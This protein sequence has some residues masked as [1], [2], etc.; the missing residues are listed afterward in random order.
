M[1]ASPRLSLPWWSKRGRSL[2]HSP[3]Y[4]ARP[5]G[6][7]SPDVS[8]LFCSWFPPT[9][10]HTQKALRVPEKKKGE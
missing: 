4:N 1:S 5:S 3:A 7:P 2:G 6:R 10:T 9:H 8:C